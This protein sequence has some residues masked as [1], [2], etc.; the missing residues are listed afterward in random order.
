MGVGVGGTSTDVEP[1]SVLRDLLAPRS[2]Q[3]DPCVSVGRFYYRSRR[4]LFTI[5]EWYFEGDD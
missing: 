4:E 1:E 3:P 5:G 2:R